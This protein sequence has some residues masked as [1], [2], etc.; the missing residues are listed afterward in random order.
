MKVKLIS[1]LLLC[2]LLTGCAHRQPTPDLPPA[3]PVQDDAPVED[4]VPVPK[5]YTAAELLRLS[6]EE[7][8]AIYGEDYTV[9]TP[10]GDPPYFYYETLG[11]VPYRFIG[12]PENAPIQAV[13][14]DV[15]GSEMLDVI[16][17]GDSYASLE[18]A[19]T[20][21]EGYEFRA[22]ASW[23]DDGFGAYGWAH[24]MGEHEQYVCYIVNEVLVSYECRAL[25]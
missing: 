9:V 6:G 5:V 17:V 3:P 12:K 10:E 7:I 18:A 13:A 20:A 19:A 8:V 21:M 15:M 11:H 4:T 22:P 24:V 23:Y 14:S 2:L 25:D 1:L 16:C